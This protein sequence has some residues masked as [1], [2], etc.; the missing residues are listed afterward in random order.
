MLPVSYAV[1]NLWRRAARTLLTIAGIALITV[2]VVL[3]TGFARGLSK[4][5][6]RTA[7]QDVVLLTAT[8][9]QHDMVRSAVGLSDA[10]VVT[11][12]L[13]H[14]LS[15]DGRRAIAPSESFV[16][17]S[18]TARNP[19]RREQRKSISRDSRY[20]PSDSASCVPPPKKQPAA[21]RNSESKRRSSRA[22]C[23]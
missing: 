12:N 11:T 22:I 1:R 16:T 20:S 3:M 13:P 15:V 18:R 9:E 10:R 5:A 23:R 17:V 14:V 19:A 2:L 6:A 21:A 7:S 4:T 8:D